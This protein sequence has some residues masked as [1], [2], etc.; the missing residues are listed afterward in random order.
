MIK[1]AT[2]GSCVTRDNFNTKFN[3][4]YK[5]YF[6]I[7]GHQ[8]QTTIPS[9]MSEPNKLEVTKEFIDKTLYVQD[10]LNKE[11]NKN[12][13]EKL[14]VEKPDYL[15]IDLDP[16]VKFGVLKLEDD[17]Y[18]TNNPNYIN[19]PQLKNLE[20]V[21]I[22]ENFNEYF[23]IWKNSLEKFFDFIQTYLPE[24]KIVLVKAR[25]TDLFKDGST[26]TDW[27]I[28][29]NI[30][31]QEFKEMNKV[32]DKFDSYIVNNYSVSI[33]D[34]TST[35]YYLDENHLWGKYYL[36]F[37][38][39][40]YN[41]FLN[42]LLNIIIKEKGRGVVLKDE[43]KT[44]QRI[45][46]DYDFEIL[47][48][49]AIEVVLNSDKNI[50]ELSRNNKKI[51]NLYKRLLKND[52]ILYFHKD[53][54]SKLYKRKFIKELWKRKDLYQENSVFYTLDEPDE[55]KMNEKLDSFTLLIIFTCMPPGDVYDSYLMSD[56]MFPKFFNNIE[57]SLVK[58]VYTMRIM[59][60]N[61]SHG[62][63]YINTINNPNMEEDIIKAI[64]N[65]KNNLDIKNIVLYGASKGGTGA[66][67][68]SSILD[69]KC[70]AVD[71]IL[72]LGE[73]NIKD[74]HFLKGLRKEDISG[75]INNYLSKK[76]N[77]EKYIIGSENVAFN[78]SMISKIK[79]EKVKVINKIDN[80]IVNHPDV[81]RNSVPE[82][83][84]L[85][86]KMLLNKKFD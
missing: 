85:L 6:Q 50:I 19:I 40:F 27:R 51:Y 1:I 34:M 55:K 7:I 83:L 5:A 21:N 71:P 46:V 62:S 80:H 39:E 24:C 36:H 47:G 26:L 4:N 33:L 9:L 18:I 61:C 32:W 22:A 56:R 76:S 69:L 78:Y 23:R 45:Y 64:E 67:Y 74:E 17:Q 3:P 63:H 43:V 81:S 53:G 41:D 60:L 48:T 54:I 65:V 14:K 79:G 8:N 29:K 12:F 15:L 72:S 52:Y 16:D 37:R 11:F 10:I 31:L 70:L 75:D 82:Q 2:I 13:L 38:K 58:N 86:N 59:D 42:K 57:R 49:K 35:Q 28:A 68:Y 44:V 73:Y 25:F 84:M 30:P 77:N 20:P 66:L